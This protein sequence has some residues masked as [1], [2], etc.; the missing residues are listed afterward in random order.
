[1]LSDMKQKGEPPSMDDLDLDVSTFK[2]LVL[3]FNIFL[4]VNVETK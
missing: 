4:E 2:A 3:T 1:M